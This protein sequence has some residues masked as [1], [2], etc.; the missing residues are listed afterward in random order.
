MKPDMGLYSFKKDIRQMFD[1][2]DINNN[3]ELTLDEFKQFALFTLEAIP[4][5]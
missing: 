1:T 3:G 4:G 2:A 5:L